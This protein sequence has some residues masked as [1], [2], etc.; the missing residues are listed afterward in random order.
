MD[1]TFLIMLVAAFIAGSI[2]AVAGGGTL[3]SFTALG[4]AMPL[5]FANATNAALLGPASISSALAFLKELRV[6]WRRFLILLIPTVLG[7]YV[8]AVV[9]VN[10]SDEIF[11]RVVPFLVLFA[12]LLFAFKDRLTVLVNRMRGTTAVSRVDTDRIP[13]PGW[14]WGIAFQFVIAFYGG[15][16]GAGIGILMISS[17]SLMGMRDMHV[18]NSLKNPLAVGINGVAAVRFVADGLVMW[19]YALPMAVCAIIGGF[20]SGRMSKRINQRYLRMFVIGYGV[21]ISAY[22]FARY[23]LGWLS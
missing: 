9:L 14:I 6:H 23:W 20:I 12:V 5:K 4:L 17:F 3:F 11:R 22:L 21:L 7:S 19:Q 18:M 8:G 1:A 10:T 15:Y 2:N 13:A 16:F